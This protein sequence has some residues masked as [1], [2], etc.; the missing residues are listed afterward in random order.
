MCKTNVIFFSYYVNMCKYEHEKNMIF[1]Y[2]AIS[3]LR[4][5]LNKVMEMKCQ[6]HEKP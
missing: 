5:I 4:L 1:D 2:G 3:C 6:G